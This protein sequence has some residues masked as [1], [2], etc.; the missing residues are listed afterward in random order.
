[1]EFF[2]DVDILLY[3]LLS[4]LNLSGHRI[5]ALYGTGFV[6]IDQSVIS[7]LEALLAGNLY[8]LLK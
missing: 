3:M 7:L 1:V 6:S 5:P 8:G 4:A 2:G